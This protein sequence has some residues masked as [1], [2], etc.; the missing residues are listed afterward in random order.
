MGSAVLVE[1]SGKAGRRL[2]YNWT[3]VDELLNFLHLAL[4]L[5]RWLRNCWGGQLLYCCR[6]YSWCHTT[7][8]ISRGANVCKT[9]VASG[10]VG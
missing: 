10:L 3:F 7:C 6:C 5:A 8:W 9:A 1:Q 2:F 4:D